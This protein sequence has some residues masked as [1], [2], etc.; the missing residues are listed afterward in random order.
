MQLEREADAA[1]G[2]GRGRRRRCG[3]AAR[4]RPGAWKKPTQAPTSRSPVERAADVVAGLGERAQQLE[5]HR[6]V[7]RAAPDRRVQADHVG[8]LGEVGDL[9]H[10]HAGRQ[11]GGVGR[12]HRAWSRSA[13]ARRR[14]QVGHA[15]HAAQLVRARHGRAAPVVARWFVGCASRSATRAPQQRGAAGQLV[16]EDVLVVGVRA[17]ADGA[18]AVEGR[19]ADAGGEVAVGRAADRRRGAA[20]AGRGR[21]ASA[22]PARTAPPRPRPP[23]AGGSGRRSTS[24]AAPGSTARSDR[25]AASTRSCSATRPH[26]DVDRERARRGHGVGGGAGAGRRSA[27]RWCR[28]RVAERGDREHL[29]GE[30]DG[31][32]DARAR[33][34]GRRARRGRA[35]ARRTG[36][37]PCARS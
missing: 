5:R 2:R 8:Q 12:L 23:A 16:D 32:V 17:A 28:R 25:I 37:R 15:I 9:A 30:L 22:R 3:C 1:A 14:G 31:G 11:R 19:R 36:R 13:S 10:G 18:E 35:R 24:S 33:A 7:L 20:P 26:P 34:R 21:A 29:V 6:R 27:S 4:P